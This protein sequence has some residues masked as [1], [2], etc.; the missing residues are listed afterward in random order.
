[1]YK[2]ALLF[3]SYSHLLN[4]HR[5]ASMM[6]MRRRI[7]GLTPEEIRNLSRDELQMPTTMDDFNVALQK[8]SKS[9][10]ATDLERYTQWM[11]EFGST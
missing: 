11:G 5:D 4:W 8:V 9:V 6:A 10:S 3:L 2:L 7:Q 1:M